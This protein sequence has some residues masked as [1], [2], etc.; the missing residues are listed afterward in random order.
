MWHRLKSLHALQTVVVEVE[1]GQ[2]S[3]GAQVADLENAL[4]LG[5]NLC[6]CG[7]ADSK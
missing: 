6:L 4:A 7:N 2:V 3:D 5:I 1:H